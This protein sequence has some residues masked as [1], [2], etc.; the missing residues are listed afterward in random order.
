[1]KLFTKTFFFFI[2]IIILQASL[3]IFIITNIIHKSNLEDAK[4]ELTEEAHAVFESYNSWKRSMWIALVGLNSDESLAEMVQ[5]LTPLQAGR[6]LF[7]YLKEMVLA[8]GIECLVIKGEG[9]PFVELIPREF[10]VL[11]L[12]DVRNLSNKK[13]HPYLQTMVVGGSLSLVGVTRVISGASAMDIFMIKRIDEAFCRQLVAN[14]RSQATF[15]LDDSFFVGSFQGK[16]PVLSSSLSDLKSAYQAFYDEEIDRSSYNIAF[17]KLGTLGDGE[18]EGQDLLL[19]TFLSNL[20]FQRRL[21]LIERTILF[22]SALGFVLT[23][24]LSLFLS[25][26]LSRPIRN[27]LNAMHHVKNGRYDTELNATP[28]TEIGELFQGFNEMA[29]QLLRDKTQMEDYIEEIVR[30]KEYNE[31]IIQSIRAG[32]AIVNPDL[33]IEKANDSFLHCFNLDA[34]RVIGKNIAELHISIIDRDILRNMRSLTRGKGHFYTKIK[35]SSDWKVYELKLYPLSGV[36]EGHDKVSGCVFTVED[37]SE[38]VELEEKIFQAEKLSSLSILSAGVAHEINNPLSSIMSNVQNLIEEEEQEDRKTSLKYIEQET[39]RI[40]RTVRELLN[41]SSA[42][43]Q[44]EAGCD[45]S[46]EIARVLSLIR[47]AIK[48]EGNIAIETSLDPEVPPAAIG[49][50]ELRQIIINL[51]NNSIQAVEREGF[52]TVSTSRNGSSGNI[53]ITV[54]DNGK[55]ISEKIVPHIFDPFFTTK[56]NGEGTG[57]GLSVVYGIVKKYNGTIRVESTEDVGTKVKIEL[58]TFK[59]WEK[60]EQRNKHTMRHSHR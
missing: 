43:P 34:Q 21:Q 57:L 8:T 26:N 13:S 56:R 51:V 45:V 12:N 35:R 50:D 29:Q 1:M 32:I 10:S 11:A 33:C 16:V 39:R 20:P 54:E 44:G 53:C 15:Y 55:G 14:R 41:F 4:K 36:H 48:K 40:A 46:R 58:P 9:Y 42:V 18:E 31:K 23:A 60:H 2:C 49:E 28:R 5:D 30:L 7:P 52:I 59:Q 17:Q 38:K 27:L 19:G 22:V 37:V 6:E 47:Y 3:A 25:R 24:V